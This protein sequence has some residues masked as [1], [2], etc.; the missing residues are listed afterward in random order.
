LGKKFVLDTSI[1]IDKE[2]TKMLYSG[3]INENDEIVIPHAVLDEL[4]AQAST[5]REHGFV[6]LQ[7]IKEIREECRKEQLN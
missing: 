5:N 6:G 4:Q 1:V 3:K 7:E 2:I